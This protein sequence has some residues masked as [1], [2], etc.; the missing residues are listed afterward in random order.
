MK[1]NF[2]LSVMSLKIFLKDLY[3]IWKDKKCSKF[4]KPKK[5]KNHVISQ[6]GPGTPQSSGLWVRAALIPALQTPFLLSCHLPHVTREQWN[7]SYIWALGKSVLISQ[8]SETLR[9]FLPIF[10]KRLSFLLRSY[11]SKP[12]LFLKESLFSLPISS[13]LA[14]FPS[15]LWHEGELNLPQTIFWTRQPGVLASHAIYPW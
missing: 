8:Y 2:Q 5:K 6:G 10:F 9:I 11:F 12:D 3:F 14:N 1:Y 15:F 13:Q 4:F 7:D